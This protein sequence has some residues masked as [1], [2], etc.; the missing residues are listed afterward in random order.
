MNRSKTASHCGTGI[1]AR[2]WEERC[3]AQGYVCGFGHG[4]VQEPVGR[5]RKIVNKNR[6]R[7]GRGSAER[8]SWWEVDGKG[9]NK[10][11]LITCMGSAVS[12]PRAGAGLLLDCLFARPV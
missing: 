8:R 4:H 2:A 3:G 10:R 6:G 7:W 9:G 1:L 11:G 12:T 5:V